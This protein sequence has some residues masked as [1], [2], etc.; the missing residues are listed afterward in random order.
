MAI[1]RNIM[2]GHVS[3]LLASALFLGGCG[4][5]LY[6]LPPPTTAEDRNAAAD[7]A[8]K[9]APSAEELDKQA[10]ASLLA[11]YALVQKAQFED[12]ERYLS[13]ETRE[14]LSAAS[15]VN[16]P[17]AALAGGEFKLRDGRSVQVDAVKL[18]FGGNIVSVQD[19]LK[20]PDTGE[21]ANRRV[22]HSLDPQGESHRIIMIFEGGQWVLH[23]T[24]IDAEQATA[25]P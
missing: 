16:D 2:I 17:S 9:P 4:S 3:L 19:A 15:D 11:L 14:F 10:R 21:T 12:A 6:H 8:A 23:M 24:S 18:L 1:L 25:A 5:S 7:Q 13:Q 22:L 20:E